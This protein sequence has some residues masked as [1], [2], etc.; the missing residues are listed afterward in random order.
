MLFLLAAIAALLLL[1]AAF[2]YVLFMNG[3]FGTVP[4]EPQV[5]LRITAIASSVFFLV[6]FEKYLIR[7]MG[8]G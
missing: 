3:L 1:Q 4:I 6:E 2:T 7:R 8:K 5:W